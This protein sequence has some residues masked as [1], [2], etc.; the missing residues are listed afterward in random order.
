MTRSCRCASGLECEEEAHRSDLRDRGERKGRPEFL[1]CSEEKEEATLEKEDRTETPK[2][3]GKEKDEGELRGWTPELQLCRRKGG[4]KGL[5]QGA[6]PNC[7]LTSSLASRADCIIAF[8]LAHHSERKVL[9]CIF[10]LAKGEDIAFGAL[11]LFV[12]RHRTFALFSATTCRIE[13]KISPLV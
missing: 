13:T 12:C 1:M 4:F 3:P 8:H 11:C 2:L 5:V 9:A 7:W 10:T 6:S